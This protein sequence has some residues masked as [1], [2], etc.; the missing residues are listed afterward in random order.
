MSSR[1]TD[2]GDDLLE[3]NGD[4]ILIVDDEEGIRKSLRRLLAPL[5]VIV[6][7]APGGAE[8]MEVVKTRRVSLII[9]DQRMPGMTGVELLQLVREIA[10]DTV[11]ILLTGYADIDATIAAINNGSIRY[12]LN[13]PW[14]D[15]FLLSRITESLEV[16]RAAVENRRLTELTAR[17]NQRLAE[18]NQTLEKRVQEQTERIRHQH[19]EVLTSFMETIKAF[20]SIIEI[21]FKEIGS[22]SQRVASL[23]EL[24][25]RHFELNQK[26]HQDIVVAAFLHDIGKISYPDPLLRKTGGGDSPA[27]QDLVSRHPILGQSC[28]SAI[29][30]FE[31]IGIIIRHH[32]EHFDGSGYP[33]G[34]LENRIPLGSRIIRLADSFDHHAFVDG[35]PDMKRINDSVAHLVQYSGVHFDPAAVKKFFEADIGKTYFHGE[36]T[37]VVYVKP[38][39]LE[40]GTVV[41]SDVHTQNGLFVIPKGAVLS[42][43]MIQRIIK[44]G[45]SD[46]IPSGVPIY[47]KRRS[48]EVRY[49][50][51]GTIVGG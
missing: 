49:E 25:L 12:Y 28:V 44:L 46:P 48:N 47:K 34:L 8:A 32:H 22:H 10:P 14:D 51:A 43:G 36:T 26:E 20:S 9:S 11:R 39:N 30:G 38:I 21:R 35:Y 13:K 42:R 18:M 24:F 5:D 29:S 19:Q 2:R 41:A 27:E 50:R 40:Q 31:E 3:T 15:E 33:E 37:E 45:K 6:L 23:T 7:D 4:V 16:H 17:Q 1:E